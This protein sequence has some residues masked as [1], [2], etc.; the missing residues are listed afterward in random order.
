MLRLLLTGVAADVCGDVAARLRGAT[1]E[2]CPPLSGPTLPACDALVCAGP[3]C[4]DPEL[5]QRFL[6]AGKHVL[7]AVNCPPFDALDTSAS[8]RLTLVNPDRY[9]PSRQLIRRQ[10]DGKLGAP[11]L[12]RLHRWEAAASAADVLDL[13]PCDLDLVAWLM[14]RAPN[15]VHAVG[16]TSGYVQVHLGFAGGGMALLDRTD[17]LPPGDGYSY[18]SV[19]GSAGAAYADDQHNVQLLYRGGAPQALRADEGTEA[20][21]TLVQEFADG[22]RAGRDPSPNPADWGQVREIMTAVRRSLE[23]RQAVALEGR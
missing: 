9:L 15:R 12:I 20:L 21:T 13:L 5:L 4:P 1:L 19:I 2:A 14:G 8:G 10:L 3:T 7:V 17:R 6:S 11:G 16:S 18:L 22:L 23:S